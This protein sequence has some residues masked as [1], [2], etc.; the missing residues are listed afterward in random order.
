MSDFQLRKFSIDV[1][2][3][4][5]TTVCGWLEP[6]IG[7]ESPLELRGVILSDGDEHHIIAAIDYCYLIG[8]SHARFEKAIADAAGI[9]VSRATI[10]ANHIHDAGMFNET[11]H[12]MMA[13]YSGQ[14]T[15]HEETF[16]A[17]I[18]SRAQDAIR[19]ALAAPGAPISAVSF[20]TQRVDQFAATRRCLD[21]NN[22]CHIRWSSGNAPGTWL[23]DYPEGPIDPDL[24]Q[25]VFFGDDDQPV[26]CISFYA[27]HPQVSNGRS[28]WSGDTIEVAQTL[29]AQVHPGVFS[30]YMTGC[31]G[32]VTAGKYT[33]N[34]KER[35]RLVFG[36]RLFDAMHGAFEKADPQPLKTLGWE[37]SIIAVPLG[38]ILEDEAYFRGRIEEPG[39]S[40][41]QQ[42]LAALKLNRLENN[43]HEYPFRLTRLTLNDYAALFL[44]SELIV[45]YQLH[46]NRTAANHFRGLAVSAY[47]DSFLNYV[48]IDESF[49][50][51]GYE[52]QPIWT[53]V[54][55]GIETPI[56]AGIDE[57]LRRPS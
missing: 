56:K 39:A 32:D 23:K 34:I 17:G 11:I 2:P 13:R 31:A 45:D 41:K 33:T 54:G 4:I 18:I 35:D 53:E 29:F 3:P 1:T 21:E 52:V 15:R 36:A 8:Q 50:Q 10:H 38:D 14:Q 55:P 42:Y 7:V 16:Y 12:A 9:P 46:A 43:I 30:M 51:G 22:K 26:A 49:T 6:A 44:P 57:I 48:A 20:A 24:S 37:D 5:G 40:L 25:I 19:A 47:G 28:I 27:C